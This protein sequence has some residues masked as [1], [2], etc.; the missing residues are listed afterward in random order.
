MFPLAVRLHVPVFVNDTSWSVVAD[1]S[2]T[3][4]RVCNFV[5]K[6]VGSIFNMSL[7]NLFTYT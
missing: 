4:W 2:V 1:V 3:C 6:F 7:L 5:N